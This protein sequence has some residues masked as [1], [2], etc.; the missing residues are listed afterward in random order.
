MVIKTPRDE[1]GAFLTV[2]PRRVFIRIDGTSQAR[3]AFEWAACNLLSPEIDEVFLMLSSK[4]RKRGAGWLGVGGARNLKDLEAERIE[5]ECMADMFQDECIRKGLNSNKVRVDSGSFQDMLREAQL[6]SC[7][8]LVVGKE[9][10]AHKED[11]SLY[12]AH[13]APFPVIVVG[14]TGEAQHEA[15]MATRGG[16]RHCTHASSAHNDKTSAQATR[17]Q[18]PKRAQSARASGVQC[19]K[20]ELAPSNGAERMLDERRRPPVSPD[21]MPEARPAAPSVQSTSHSKGTNKVA[22]GAT[23]GPLSSSLER[24]LNTLEDTDESGMRRRRTHFDHAHEH[25]AHSMRRRLSSLDESSHSESGANTGATQDLQ[26]SQT[27]MRRIATRCSIKKV[28]SSSSC[29]ESPQKQAPGRMDTEQ[30]L[31]NSETLRHKVTRE[32]FPATKPLPRRDIP[33]RMD[34]GEPWMRDPGANLQMMAS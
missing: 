30:T 28:N 20:A 17:Q 13:N 7:D 31:E 2:L 33:P 34:L 21:S 12:A 9:F 1:V 22:A 26:A 5:I 27:G 32:T 23:L 8:L 24:L 4:Y 3:E 15:A 25:D 14:D 6:G 19:E 18:P 10:G 11:A 16:H 29:D